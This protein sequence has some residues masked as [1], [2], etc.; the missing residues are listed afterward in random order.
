ME[1]SFKGFCFMRIYDILTR[2]FVI[3]F[4]FF[5][6]SCQGLESPDTQEH[7]IVA[8]LGA[9]D[10]KANFHVDESP[11]V[12]CEWN[13]R[14]TLRVYYKRPNGRYHG[15]FADARIAKIEGNGKSAEFTYNA[16]SEWGLVGEKNSYQVAIFTVNCIPTVDPDD[17][18]IYLDARLIRQPLKDFELPVYYV[19]E[20]VN[21][22]VAATFSHY[23]T[24]E[25]LHVKNLSDKEIDFSLNGYETPWIWYKK[26][27][28][29]GL[30][31]GVIY[32]KSWS[33]RTPAE[34]SYPI[35]IGP[36]LSDIIVSAYI[37]NDF[38]MKDA[39]IVATIDGNVVKS[40]N[41]KSSAAPLLPGRA[42]HMYATWDGTE[43]KFEDPGVSS[44]A[45][46]IETPDI[47]F[48]DV[49]VGTTAQEYLTIHNNGTDEQEVKVAIEGYT[50][51]SPY[52]LPDGEL[53][54]GYA[55]KVIPAGE[56]RSFALSFRPP[57]LGEYSGN[58]VV[59]SEGLG[60]WQCIVPLRGKGIEEKVDDS[61]HLSENSIEIYLHS[62]KVV[63][64]YNGS[65]EYEVVNENPDIVDYDI[66][67][68][69]VAHAP[70]TRSDGA[71]GRPGSSD[72]WWIT[73]KKLGDATLRLTDK[74]TNEELTLH[75][76]VI[77]AP[78][79]ELES[80][81]VE[82]NLGE[83]C[84]VKI[85]NGSEWYQVTSDD[86]S[87]VTA[88][89]ATIG[90]GG[91]GGRYGE[92]GQDTGIY[93]VINAISAGQTS[94]R[95]KDLSSYEE[96][97]IRV[98]VKGG[99]AIPDL[100]DLGL[101]VRWASFNLGAT[102]PEEFGDYYAWGETEPYHSSLSPLAWK[103][104][105]GSGYDWPSYQWCKGN[106]YTMT[107][108]SIISTYGYNGF[109]D[110]KTV[111]DLEDDA[112]HSNFGGKW[113]MPTAEEYDDLLQ[114]CTWTWTT[115]NGVSGYR[116][117]GS[118]G[119]YIFLPAAGRFNGTTQMDA[120]TCGFYWS[121]SVNPDC[122]YLAWSLFTYDM[123]SYT[124]VDYRCLGYPIRP[125]SQ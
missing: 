13:G 73:A 44:G 79:L 57:S 56:S 81:D 22:S 70:A 52:D 94:V 17:G 124:D 39:S 16:E 83:E 21:G 61:F 35:S 106:S 42:Y 114:K 88:S 119:N 7:K 66:N 34:V 26:L 62:D 68:I 18:S 75:V 4:S 113:R 45:L 49:V 102:R 72:L 89:K 50:Y 87:I 11:N 101:T 40:S 27:A 24:Y 93:V 84:R 58:A 97:V 53:G 5:I 77:N 23:Y 111:L 30:E 103:A 120:G 59:T 117:T 36:G 41:K 10:T 38:I 112:V 118:N 20:V 33:G 85:L 121:S 19:G 100:V 31:D 55:Y 122:S 92:E 69:H 60:G 78:S 91:G 28:S 116:V 108:Y 25:F 37:P 104:G 48:G 32:N 76:K 43:L 99:G 29:V 12:L 115:H 54:D 15:H 74:Q 123:D 47:Q 14:E 105:K 46:E 65:G 98:T 63:D 3:T 64:I 1:R 6:L 2:A 8:S 51:T 96:A 95:V 107:K 71:T 9:Y 67:G 109:T 110:G 90:S 86:E 125:V 82:M 80:T